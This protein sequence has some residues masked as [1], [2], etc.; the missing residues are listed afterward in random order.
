MRLRLRYLVCGI[1]LLLLAAPTAGA[2]DYV[3]F[4]TGP[5]RPLARSADGSQLFVANIPDNRLEIFDVT[6]AGLIAVASVPVGLE[7]CSVAVAPNGSVWVVNHM[8]DSVSIVD[9]NASPP[10]VI[11]TLLVGDEPRDIVFASNNC[12]TSAPEYGVEQV[13]V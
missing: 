10:Q 13:R 1:G 3:L 7:P 11:Q 4:E 6:E 2:M 9:I 5:V 12:R 8:S